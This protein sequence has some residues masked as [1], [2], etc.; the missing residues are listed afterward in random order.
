MRPHA[1]C[2]GCW[3]TWSREHP[4][5]TPKNVALSEP[6]TCCRC[7]HETGSGIFARAEDSALMCKGEGPEHEA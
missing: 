5:V 6:S 3:A 2:W 4:T 1:F 7:G